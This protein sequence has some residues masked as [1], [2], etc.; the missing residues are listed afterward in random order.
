LSGWRTN[1]PRGD[2]TNI[3]DLKR[4]PDKNYENLQKAA[5]KLFKNYPPQSG[6]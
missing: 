2:A 4:D 1:G 6:K 5:A 3:V